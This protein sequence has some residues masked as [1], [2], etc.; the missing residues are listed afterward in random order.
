MWCESL[1]RIGLQYG[2]LVVVDVD[3]YGG[4]WREVVGSKCIEAFSAGF[5]GAI[6]AKES[7]AEVNA[8]LRNHGP[9]AI[10]LCSR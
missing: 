2:L 4:R 5:G 8:N 9:T 10:A 6:S 7:T 1:L 3:A